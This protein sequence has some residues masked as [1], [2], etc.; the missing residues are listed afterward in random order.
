MVS[1]HH[2][3]DLFD[4]H[5]HKQAT[6]VGVGASDGLVCID[7]ARKL[8]ELMPIVQDPPKVI[9]AIAKNILENIP[10]KITFLPHNLFEVLL[11]LKPGAGILINDGAR[12]GATLIAGRMAQ[13][14]GSVGAFVGIWYVLH[15]YILTWTASCLCSCDQLVAIFYGFVRILL[16]HC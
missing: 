9:A 16:S 5:A 14:L 2:I 10:K 1:R 13:G 3:I 8:S 6:V 4:W 11:G 7:L 15:N 12:N